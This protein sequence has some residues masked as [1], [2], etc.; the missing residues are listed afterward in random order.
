[1]HN[2]RIMPEAV[3]DALGRVA[4]FRG[5]NLAVVVASL[6]RL[7]AG[8]SR[9]GLESLLAQ[10][11]V[12]IK[13]LRAAVL[14][15]RA[16]GQID[17][18]VHTAGMLLYL[19]ELLED[20]EQIQVV[21]LGAGNTGKAFDLVTDR[22]IAEFTFID[23]KGG[24][25]S[26]RKQ[27][28]FK[29]FYQLAE[30]GTAKR[31]YLYFLGDDYAPK[32]FRSRS[33]CKGMLRKFAILRDAFLQH[34]EPTLSVRDYYDAKKGP[35][36]IAKSGDRYAKGGSGIRASAAHGGMNYGA[37][38]QRIYAQGDEHCHACTR[39][40]IGAGDSCDAG[41]HQGPVSRSGRIVLPPGHQAASRAP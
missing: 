35:C 19:P 33:S 32:V 12:T 39:A 27:K 6:E 14:V 5:G 21:S 28:L 16:A 31:R 41:H 3:V 13:L 9:Q 17:A 15:K 38:A 20:D 26:I 29:D 25:E 7:V 1:M 10:E 40:T 36:D 22:R 34:Y 37:A 23:W 4:R 2:E 18:V 8:Q 30:S 11:L 24:S